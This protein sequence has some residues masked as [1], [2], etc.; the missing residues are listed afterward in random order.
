MDSRSS[1]TKKNCDFLTYVFWDMPSSQCCDDNFVNEVYVSSLVRL[2]PRQPIVVGHLKGNITFQCLPGSSTTNILLMAV[3]W[4]L[5]GSALVTPW[6][7]GI[8][9]FID[10]GS[11]QLGQLTIINL[12][13]EYNLTTIQCRGNLSSSESQTSDIV[14]LLLQGILHGPYNA[15]NCFYAAPNFSFV[16]VFP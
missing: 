15:T 10:S 14:D 1:N 7:D 8:I 13:V 5:N 11:I 16:F 4:L 2:L 12:R 3:T 9:E 6:S